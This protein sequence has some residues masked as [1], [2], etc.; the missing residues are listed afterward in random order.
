M[1]DIFE[2]IGGK[3]RGKKQKKSVML[4]TDWIWLSTGLW[5]KIS[6]ARKEW[7]CD[8][9]KRKL[10]ESFYVHYRDLLTRYQWRLCLKCAGDKEISNLYQK[11]ESQR[12]A[13]DEE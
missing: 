12:R 7:Q 2:I 10:R 11:W 5:A 8:R 4:T 6:K 3:V 9:C 1:N 13:K